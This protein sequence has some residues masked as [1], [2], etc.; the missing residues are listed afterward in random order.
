MTEQQHPAEKVKVAEDLAGVFYERYKELAQDY[1]QTIPSDQASQ[2]GLV[3]NVVWEL[4]EL[5]VIVPGPR[6]APEGG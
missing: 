1:G 6:K 2:K 4:I 3:T 5:G